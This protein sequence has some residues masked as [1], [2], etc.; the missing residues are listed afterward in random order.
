[1][2]HPI[3]YM[4]VEQG[5]LDSS[6][7]LYMSS[8]RITEKLDNLVNL[9]LVYPSDYSLETMSIQAS[10]TLANRTLERKSGHH[11]PR[12]DLFII[13]GDETS[14]NMGLEFA[15]NQYEFLKRLRNQ[16]SFSNFFNTP[17]SE[18][19]TM[20][21]QL[22]PLSQDSSLGI[23]RTYNFENYN[24]AQELLGNY[25]QVVLKPIF[26]CRGSGVR[27]ISSIDDLANLGLQ[28]EELKRNYVL[29]EGLFGD[30]KRIVLL[31]GNLLCSR[32]HK[33]RRTPWN[34]NMPQQTFVYQPSLQELDV[35]RKIASELGLTLAGV[36]FIG[37]KVNEINGTGTGIVIPDH[38]GKL[39]YDKTDVFVQK[40]ME[41]LK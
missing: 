23:A 26:G 13:Y 10:Y 29:Q 34:S 38:T 6:P 30:E 31:D 21:N 25:G 37:D 36:D 28:E 8:K 19:K 35:S 18:E 9:S 14:K 12:G 27:L 22:V 5:F 20:K 24:Q 15:R 32:I 40:V 39:L 11:L 16:K 1:M 41:L 3:V 2:N 7:N 17:E 4:S 33:N